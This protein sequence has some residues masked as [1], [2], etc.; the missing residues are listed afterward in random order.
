MSISINF[1]NQ[2]RYSMSRL[3]IL[4]FFVFG[5]ALVQAQTDP[6]TLSDRW[7]KVVDKSESYQHYKV[8]KKTD[9]KDVWQAVQD[10]IVLYKSSLKQEKATIQSQQERIQSLENEARKLNENL[11]QLTV[12]KDSMTFMNSTVDKYAYAATLWIIMAIIAI[13]CAILFFLYKNS[14]K[15][16]RQKINEHDQLFNAF[17]EHKKTTLERE[18]KL[19]RELQTQSNLIEELKTS[20]RRA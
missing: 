6:V 11:S 13:S 20:T 5:F 15:V 12:S 10:T 7:E 3:A 18:R 1:R 4:I 17:E 19:K 16:T 14:H 8:I 2:N 9:L